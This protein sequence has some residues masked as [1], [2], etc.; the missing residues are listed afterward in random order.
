MARLTLRRVP[1]V[2]GAATGEHPRRPARP[3]GNG[4]LLGSGLERLQLS[5]LGSD[6]SRA[7][8]EA[9]VPEAVSNVVAALLEIAAGNPL[10]LRELSARLSE[11]QRL[12]L[13][14]ID[15]VKTGGVA[16]LETFEAQLVA[17]G[18]EDREAV[19]VAS[20]ALDRGLAPVIAACRDL[21]LEGGAL[22][23]AEAAGVLSIGSDRLS[24]AHPLVKAVAYEQTTP[25]ERRRAH[26]ALAEHCEADARAWH[27][28]A[29]SVGPDD[30]VA[31][32]LE[33]AARRAAARGATAL[34]PMPSS[35]QRASPRTQT[36]APVGFMQQPSQRRWAAPTI[37][38]RHFWSR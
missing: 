16:L 2:R 35:G 21:G 30:A 31:E 29:A 37:A 6:D 26:R 28:A 7:L 27:L 8:V 36:H 22:E 25:A 10:A 13:V 3:G 23:R 11:D 19:V 15:V 17:L 5:G 38:V 4:P 24:F 14:P 1:W 12:G 33:G 20:A 32:L 34:P 9:S 18:S